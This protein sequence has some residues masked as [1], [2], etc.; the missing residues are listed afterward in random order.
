MSRSSNSKNILIP[1]IIINLISCTNQNTKKDYLIQTTKTQEN[2][3]AETNFPT[4]RFKLSKTQN[5]EIEEKFFNIVEKNYIKT[6]ETY[7]INFNYTITPEGV[8]Y[9]YSEVSVKCLTDQ[10]NYKNPKFEENCQHFFQ[11]INTEISK[12]KEVNQWKYTTP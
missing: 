1:I 6:Y 10:K 12:L 11:L 4:Q 2:P 9:P 5:Y 3:S 7:N 8:I